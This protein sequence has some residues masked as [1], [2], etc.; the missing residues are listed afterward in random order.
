MSRETDEIQKSL[1][2]LEAVAKCSAAEVVAQVQSFQKGGDGLDPTDGLTVSILCLSSLLDRIAVEAPAV[3]ET[4]VVTAWLS[5]QHPEVAAW[6]R[7]GRA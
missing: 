5:G 4:A 1:S 6:L 2:A 7:V 3:T